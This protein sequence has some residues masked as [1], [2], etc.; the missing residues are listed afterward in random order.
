MFS[1]LGSTPTFCVLEH[2]IHS[3]IRLDW[4]P[5]KDLLQSNRDNRP[6]SADEI[7]NLLLVFLEILVACGVKELAHS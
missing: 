1:R 3:S 4:L 5:A 2:A 7:P 6:V